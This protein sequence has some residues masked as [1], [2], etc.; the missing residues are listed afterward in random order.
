MTPLSLFLLLYFLLSYLSYL[1]SYPLNGDFGPS[2]F[3]LKVV[4]TNDRPFIKDCRGGRVCPDR[5]IFFF[6]DLGCFS[7]YASNQTTSH[8]MTLTS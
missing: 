7:A 5:C 3:F 4:Y 6:S 8:C 1:L 2:Y